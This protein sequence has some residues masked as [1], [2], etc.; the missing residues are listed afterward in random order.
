MAAAAY[1]E[2]FPA[3][4]EAARKTR[5]LAD[6]L[7]ATATAEISKHGLVQVRLEL[8]EDPLMQPAAAAALAQDPRPAIEAPHRVARAAPI[9]HA[10][11]HAR[12]RRRAH[13]F[14]CLRC[15]A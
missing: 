5:L 14:A 13:P 2:R 1:E 6:G 4:E 10:R 3:A 7:P 15:Q 11:T 12:A 8:E 9:A